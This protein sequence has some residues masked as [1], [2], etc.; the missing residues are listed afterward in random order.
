MSTKNYLPPTKRYRTLI[1]SIHSIYRL[2]NST[3]DLKDLITRLSKLISQILNSDYCT[4]TMLEPSK[5]YSILRCFVSNKKRSVSDKKAK[6]TD[7][8]EKRILRTSSVVRKGHL[9]AAPLISD[10]LIGII[11]IRR[12][13]NKPFFEKFDQDILMTLVE[14]SIIGIKNLQ[15][16]EEQQKIVFGSIKSLV[17]LLD[18]RVPQ[19]YTHSPYFSRLVTAIGSQMRLDEKQIQSLKYASFLHD[20]GK[21][22]IPPE[23]LTKTT[24]LTAQ[25]YNIIKRHPLKG[26]QILRPLQVLKPVIPIIMHH[27]ER[28]DGTG[29]PSRLKKGQI[30]QGARIMAV[31]DAFEAMV[32]GRPY[33]ER[34]NIISAIKEVKK[35]SGSQFDPKVV[36]AF[37]KVIR[38][39]N[40]KVYSK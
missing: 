32:Y 24:K 31:A 25:E 12:A 35:K 6:I 17:T 22:D 1:S 11:V 9:L 14:Q 15:L 27:H 34:K 7:S 16:Y 4:I 13:K 21:V 2:V 29:Y 30:P 5:K 10:D 40:T 33:R 20:T 37:L 39:F 36:D 23:I 28:Y 18:T 38:K 19:E 26:A 3:Y 8:I